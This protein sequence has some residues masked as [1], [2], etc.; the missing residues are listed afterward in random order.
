MSPSCRILIVPGSTLNAGTDTASHA[1][2]LAFAENKATAS[3]MGAKHGEATGRTPWAVP[4]HRHL[5]APSLCLGKWLSEQAGWILCRY[6]L[7]TPL[8]R[9][10][11]LRLVVLCIVIQYDRPPFMPFYCSSTPPHTATAQ[12]NMG[13]LQVCFVWLFPRGG[14]ARPSHVFYP[15][16]CFRYKT[17]FLLPLAFIFIVRFFTSRPIWIS[18]A[19]FVYKCKLRSR[20]PRRKLLNQGMTLLSSSTMCTGTPL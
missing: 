2:S 1:H 6:Q 15:F 12:N 9:L 19:G 16:S 10:S 13:W 4:R 14:C 17:A 8:L 20:Y 18:S 7:R 5:T 11:Q 3:G